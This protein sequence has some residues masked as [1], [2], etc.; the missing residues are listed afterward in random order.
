MNKLWFHILQIISLF[1]FVLLITGVISIAKDL[2]SRQEEL[3]FK[4]GYGIG[5]VLLFGLLFWWN[6]KLYRYTSGKIKS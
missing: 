4:I 3:A 1:G 5:A 2:F 6:S